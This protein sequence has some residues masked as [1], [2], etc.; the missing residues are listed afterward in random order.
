MIQ[1]RPSGL[2]LALD[3][4]KVIFVGSYDEQL[5]CLD[6]TDGELVWKAAANG[7]VALAAVVSADGIVVAGSGDGRVYGQQQAANR[8]HANL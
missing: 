4:R 6:Q 8:L 3:G 7:V 1:S 2:T 5:Y